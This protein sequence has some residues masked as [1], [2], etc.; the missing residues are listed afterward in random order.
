MLIPVRELVSMLNLRPDG[1]LHVGAHLGEEATMYESY[2][3]QGASKI[4]WVE[5]QK[6]LAEEVQRV[7]NPSIHQVTCAT[8]WDVSGEVLTFNKT[9]NTQSSSLLKLKEHSEIYPDITVTE[10]IEVV[11]SRLDEIYSS[12]KFN[13][14]AL[15][16]QG[17]ELHALKGMGQLL[18]R[19]DWVY[20]EVN[21]IELYSEC[22]L[23]DEID[24]FLIEHGFR[25]IAVRWA[26]K[27][28]WGDAIWVRSSNV[29]VPKAG[30]L[31]IMVKSAGLY[32]LGL[33]K[34]L[35]KK[36]IGMLSALTR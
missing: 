22:S 13:F 10:T 6:D 14:L 20:S 29:S 2:G 12:E 26:F 30:I 31:G 9:S 4:Y 25:R 33:S 24:V 5:S 36:A 11:T 23:I 34:Y 15:D 35:L 16:I 18:D 8:V 32:F 7:L 1:V 19:V 28:G 17:A 21:K 27:A 3:W